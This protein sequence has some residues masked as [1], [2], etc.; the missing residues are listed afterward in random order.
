MS[1]Q[2]NNITISAY[3]GEAPN[4]WTYDAVIHY[5]SDYVLSSMSEDHIA[6]GASQNVQWTLVY[7]H[8]ECTSPTTTPPTT[9]T[10]T[11]VTTPTTTPGPTTAPDLP[12]PMIA[13]A[14]GIFV[15]VAAV[16]LL[17]RR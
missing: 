5:T 11:P 8:S 10:T 1:R 9:P 16:I 7:H 14:G 17:K 13:T 2:G 15:L 4:T 6:T 3:G 12:I